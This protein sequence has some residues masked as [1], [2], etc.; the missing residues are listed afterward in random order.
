MSIVTL[1][2]ARAHLNVTHDFDDDLIQHY[3]D[4]AEDYA[5]RYMGR[6][7]LED[8]LI[9]PDSD[10]EQSSEQPMRLPASV[11]QAVLLLV[12]DYYALREAQVTGTI[13]T[14]NPAAEAL[15]HFYRVGLGA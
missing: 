2:R 5:A 12:G 14:Q 7:S 8:L 1:E 3:I 10:S 4:A 6:E 13:L 9:E 11:E 15:M